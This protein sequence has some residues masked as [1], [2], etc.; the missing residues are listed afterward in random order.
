MMR[1]G[2]LFFG[3]DNSMN[4][5]VVMRL[6]L[7]LVLFLSQTGCV[8]VDVKVPLDKDVNKT[9]LGS[10]IGRSEAHSILW[11]I[12]WGDAGTAAAAKDGG[13]TTITH[14]DTGYESYLFGAYSKRETIAYGD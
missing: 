6:A 1:R 2:S 13:I 10:K 12:A 11:L 14:L 7:L 9:E 8:Y 5:K 3:S 4:A